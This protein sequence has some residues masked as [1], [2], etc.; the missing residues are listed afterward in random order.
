MTEKTITVRISD[1]LHKEI[2]IHIA[3]NGKSLKDY[4]VEL[5]QKDL[6]GELG[7]KK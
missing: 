1:E 2:K 7:E 6:H 4:I 5:I 3:K